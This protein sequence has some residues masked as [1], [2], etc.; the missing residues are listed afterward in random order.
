MSLTPL[1][2]QDHEPCS[3]FIIPSWINWLFQYKILSQKPLQHK[4]NACTHIFLH[5]FNRHYLLLLAQLGQP[6]C[7]WLHNCQCSLGWPMN[8]YC[9]QRKG[10]RGFVCYLSC[11]YWNCRWKCHIRMG[12]PLTSKSTWCC[13][14]AFRKMHLCGN[15]LI[16]QKV[17]QKY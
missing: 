10:I 3:T 6:W 7:W 14:F 5:T 8:L 4:H 13:S 17:L 9:R 15:F 1:Q 11:P 16:L 12:V 2:M